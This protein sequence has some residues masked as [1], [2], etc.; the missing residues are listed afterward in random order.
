MNPRLISVNAKAKT[1]KARFRAR[2]LRRVIVLVCR[3]RATLTLGLAATVAFA[4]LHTAS[5]G[6]AFPIFK[7]LL[8]EEGLQGWTDRTIAGARLGVGFVPPAADGRIALISLESDSSLY[9]QGLQPGDRI[10]DAQ[11][12]SAAELLGDLAH[13]GTGEAIS[14]Q[15][16]SV[17]DSPG[18]PRSLTL[19]PGDL[20]AS[21]RLLRWAG[22]FIP[23]DA[24]QD[25]FRTLMFLLAGLVGLIVM[26]NVFRYFGEVLIAEA[27]LRAM[28]RLR[29]DL[30]ERTLHLPMSFFS[31][32]PTSDLVGRFVQDIQEI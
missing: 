20:D 5:V 11:G 1:P 19:R 14:V 8:E 17:T 25:K 2:E 21:M 26:G 6:G 31:G 27:I 15:T 9:R 23:G 30:Y 18:Q 10:W 22:S 16:D 7:L 3:Y 28:M 29:S 32:K 13:A 24:D 12:R 4:C